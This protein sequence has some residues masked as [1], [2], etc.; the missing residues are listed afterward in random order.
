M[1]ELFSI[2]MLVFIRYAA[3]WLVYLRRTAVWNVDVAIDNEETRSTLKTKRRQ[4]N[5]LIYFGK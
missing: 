4:K 5:M 3:A 2:A 1:N